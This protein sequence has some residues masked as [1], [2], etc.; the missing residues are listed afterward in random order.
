MGDDCT[1]LLGFWWLLCLHV[2]RGV[3]GLW[4]SES[5]A[6]NTSWSG[7]G[8]SFVDDDG[9]KQTD[10]LAKFQPMGL[11]QFLTHR[12]YGLSWV[13]VVRLKSRDDYSLIYYKKIVLNDW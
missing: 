8:S 1:S 4:E 10:V 13:L 6:R 9:W 3:Y 11:S 2:R 5:A 12:L 7:L